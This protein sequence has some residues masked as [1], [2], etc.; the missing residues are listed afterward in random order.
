MIYITLVA[1]LDTDREGQDMLVQ[2][3]SFAGRWT[4]EA[5]VAEVKQ[6][7]AGWPEH[8]VLEVTQVLVRDE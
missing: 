2:H 6:L 7:V 1:L 3:W 5:A 4:N 8:W